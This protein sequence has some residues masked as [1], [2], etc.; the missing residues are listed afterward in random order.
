MTMC[1]CT[2]AKLQCS[3]G[4]ASSILNVLPMNRVVSTTPL[5]TVMDKNPIINIPPFAMCSSPTN[6]QVI[7]A[8]AAAMGAPTPAP[9]VP[10]LP[11]P[12]APGSPT[13]LIGGYPALN[14]TCK[15]TCAWGG[16]IQIT[17]PSIKNIQ[18]P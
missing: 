7:A 8:T 3:F 10:I 1:V 18:V 2:G 13:V 6:P 17:D 4:A 12:W 5:A 14:K 16:I 15:L 11:A 9:C